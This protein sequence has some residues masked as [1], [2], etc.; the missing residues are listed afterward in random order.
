MREEITKRKV[1]TS[2]IWNLLERFSGQI[3]QFILSIFLARILLPE[4]YGI[5]ALIQIFIQ[6]ANVFVIDGFN[7]SLIQKKDSDDLD[8]SSVFHFTTGIAIFLYIMMFFLAPVIAGFYGKQIITNVIRIFSLSFFYTPLLSCQYAFIE[9]HMMFKVYFLRSLI[10]LII[11]GTVAI[12]MALQG[13]GVYA[14]VIQQ[15]IYGTLNSIILFIFIKWRPKLLFSFERIKSLFSFGWKFTCVGFIDCVF[16]NIYSLIIGK[17]YDVTQLSYYN[18]GQQFPNLIA[19]NFVSS[20]K[21]VLFPT[22]SSKN[23]DKEALKNMLKKS[24][25]INAYLILPLMFGMAA[26]AKP[27]VYVLLTEKWEAS[28]PFVQ[29]CCLYF[30]FYNL[31][32]TNM[33]AINALGRSDIFLRCEIIKKIVTVLLLV[34]TI[35]FGVLWMVLGQVL[36]GLLSS[37][38]NVFPTKKLFD[39][40]IR[41]QISDISGSLII[42]TV[43]GILT[44]FITYLNFSNIITLI[45]QIVFGVAFYVIISYIFKLKGFKYIINFLKKNKQES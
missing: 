39:Y 34:A 22:F 40:S 13:F 18:R 29:L 38:I 30:A 41:E 37:I 24:S 42:S 10:C 32:A 11:S 16:R 5:V 28:I 21:N 26:V 7:T 8:F 6:L 35:P 33:S 4:D 31:N 36:T 25:V 3:L 1:L 9:K 2:F 12:I 45:L 23:D 17:A 20:L 19:T 14:L 27:M 44:L 15:L 43:M